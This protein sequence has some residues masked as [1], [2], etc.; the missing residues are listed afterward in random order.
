MA[1][2]LILVLNAGSSTLKAGLFDA[3]T[4]DPRGDGVLNPQESIDDFLRRITGTL[5]DISAVGHRIVH[6]G[7]RFR[8]PTRL[9]TAVLSELER[10]TPL[11]PL[12]NPPA[13]RAIEAARRALPNVPHVAVFDTAFFAALPEHR[14]VYPLPYAWYKEWGIRRFGFHGISHAYCADR[15]AAMLN[16]AP[17]ETSVIVCHLGNGCSATAVQNGTPVATTM[18]FTPMEGLMMGTRSGSVDPGILFYLMREKS[19]TPAALEDAL[20]HASGLAGVS[21]LSG[22]LREVELAA[23]GGDQRA[24]LATTLYAERV[25]SAIGAFVVFMDRLDAVVF[26][27]GVGEHS[28]AMRDAIVGRLGALGIALDAGKNATARPDTD[29]ATAGSKARVLVIHTREELRIA[30]DVQR[31][32]S[33]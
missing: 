6:G 33:A 7:E 30:R 13:L 3:A 24:T 9:T 12:H 23:G 27:A 29:V 16:R 10:L 26:T 8:A 19:L 20:N 28:A 11:S 32:L 22:D 1:G 31:A 2:R 17:S 4:L 25:A 15:A 21:G 14:V 5:A 18:G